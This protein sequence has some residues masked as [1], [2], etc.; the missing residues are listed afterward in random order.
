MIL[1]ALLIVITTCAA[2]PALAQSR[3][4]LVIGIDSYDNVAP[5]Q[6]ARN[7]AEAVSAALSNN[8]FEVTTL[9]DAD[10]RDFTRALSRFTSAL[11][12]GDEAVFYFAGHGIEVQGR[13]YLLPADVPE[14]RPGD[15][16]FLTSESLAADEILAAIQGRGARVSVLIL[17]ACRD[18]PFPAQGT[19]SL[20]QTRGLARVD[21]PEG[22]FVMFS[23]GTGQAALDRLSDDD[24]D[25]NSV[26]TRA[27]LPLLSEPGLPIHEVARQLRREVTEM[28]STIGY[29]QRPAYYDEV[30]GDFIL[31]SAP[32]PD[33][34]APAPI[35]TP[36]AA[37]VAPA[38]DPAILAARIELA[39]AACEGAAHPAVPTSDALLTSNAP[40]AELLCQEVLNLA[41][42]P[43]S[44]EF[45]MASALL[46]RS[47]SAQGRFDEA[48]A[49]FQG[50]ADAGNTIAIQNLAQ[51]YHFGRGIDQ[52]GAEAAR[53]YQ[54][55]L[56]RGDADV[57]V[58]ETAFH[59]GMLYAD[60]LDIGQ[61]GL[62]AERLFRIAANA[63]NLTAYVEW[64]ILYAGGIGVT[65]NDAEAARLYQSAV[66]AGDAQG[67]YMLGYMY[68]SG[69]GVTRDL[70]R[71]AQLFRAGADQGYGPAIHSLAYLYRFGQGVRQDEA[72]ALRLYML[73]ANGG[74]VRSIQQMGYI[75]ERGAIGVAQNYNEAFQ[76]YLRAAEAD[77]IYSIAQVGRYYQEG[78][79]VPVNYQEA[80]SWYQRG[81]DAGYGEA[82]VG[83]AWMYET[84]NGGVARDPVQAASWYLQA[85]ADGSTWPIE[86]RGQLSQEVVEE[87]QRSLQVAGHYTSAI[88]GDAGPGTARAMQAYIDAQ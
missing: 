74:N 30:T 11:E 62:E 35:D 40:Q 46:G 25:P 45:G 56:D 29:N 21:A 87:L 58:A 2:L 41:P 5:L 75:Y 82:M 1:R 3:H 65:R 54:A 66:D 88:D 19:R 14:M 12:P 36:V 24:P 10:R 32:A 71:A 70:G 52:D 38:E 68:Q 83:V 51:S 18:N 34:P 33:I 79:G 22:A 47:L 63:G 26:F 80:L 16:V 67:Q 23:A 8:G 9:L 78:R 84:G 72:E 50:G 17:D 86:N 15:E 20:G 31:S 61:N 6:K 27:L 39:L 69:R 85:M 4:A 37:P 53:L 73:A 28:A 13:N 64:G 77:D 59:L 81:A 60:G 57:D 42:S 48:I 7:D 55:A 49:A 44:P 76:W 43:S